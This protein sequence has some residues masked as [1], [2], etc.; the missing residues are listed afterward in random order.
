M[1]TPNI[2]FTKIDF[3]ALKQDLI[4]YIKNTSEFN[5]HD[6]AGSN[7]NL[8]MNLL[9]YVTTLLSYNLNQSINENYLST[10]DLR[11]NILKIVKLLNYVPYRKQSSQVKVN[12]SDIVLS[13]DVGAAYLL[14]Y[15]KIS[16]N[17]LNF[18][19]TGEQTEILDTT[20]NAITFY[21]GTLNTL[22]TAYTG[23][24]TDF[25]SFI[26]E[27]TDIGNYLSIYTY[28]NTDILNP[29]RT[30]WTEFDEGTE[31]AD[32][33][34]ALIYFIE[35]VTEG[36]KISFGNNKLGKRPA[37]GEKIGYEFIVPTGT[38]A[39][40]LATFS[41]VGGG[42]SEDYNVAYTEKIISSAT[43]SLD[44]DNTGSYGYSDKESIAEIKFNAPK[45][46]NT[47]ARAVTEDDYYS[48]AI[49]H[50][51]ISKASAIGGEKITNPTGAIKLGKVYISVKPEPTVYPQPR[52]IADDLAT[53]KDYFL[54]YSVVTIEPI[55]LNPQIIYLKINTRLRYTA[56]RSPSIGQ[57]ISDI[58]TFINTDNSDFGQYLEFSK[59]TAKIDSA[60]TLTTSN[61]T[62]MEKYV[63]LS[64]ENYVYDGEFVVP[65]EYR[66]KLPKNLYDTTQTGSL[67]KTRIEQFDT[68]TKVI[69][70]NEDTDYT[71]E[72]LASDYVKIKMVNTGSELDIASQTENNVV[73]GS[74][75]SNGSTIQKI[76]PLGGTAK[77]TDGTVYEEIV[78]YTTYF[79]MY[80]SLGIPNNLIQVGQIVRF[81]SGINKNKLYRVI[82]TGSVITDTIT[83]LQKY[84][85]DL[86]PITDNSTNFND[87]KKYDLFEVWADINLNNT[88][89]ATAGEFIKAIGVNVDF[90]GYYKI[91]SI[92][93]VDGAYIKIDTTSVA[94]LKSLPT[95]VLDELDFD[96][97]YFMMQPIYDFRF[98]FHTQDNDL[99]LNSN[100]ILNVNYDENYGIEKDITITTEKV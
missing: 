72:Y 61:L 76:Y 13:V 78:D 37:L 9:A 49:K 84:Y 22:T 67:L 79:T 62:T 96:G 92:D 11:S 77:V 52:F 85:L 4:D 86:E 25:Q 7:L 17:G 68:Y 57:T 70:Y 42:K 16:S 90:E 51:L 45:F 69:T 3:D 30:Q 97:A 46:F 88:G 63:T 21:E 80:Y 18:Y 95:F 34:N 66:V 73:I 10:A 98:F 71:V 2:D 75:Y 43:I 23:D 19:Y 54:K 41:W 33:G 28:D 58:Q 74:A 50:P 82:G 99:F 38:T 87:I 8:V 29:I 6:F 40:S 81:I 47:Q 24:D 26:I 32:S 12:L 5:S 44:A 56:D 15:D 36:Y 59:L 60:D 31:Y 1:A 48:I 94:G 53:L 91:E 39:D 20:M 83:Q 55:V 27:N 35:E 93:P 100:Q 89:Y 65:G 64:N 14:K